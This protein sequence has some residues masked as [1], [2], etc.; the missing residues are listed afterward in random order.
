MSTSFTHQILAQ[1]E[2]FTRNGQHHNK[3]YMLLKHLVDEK[4]ARFC[5]ILEPH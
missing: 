1:I 2:L 4:V 3:V 5:R